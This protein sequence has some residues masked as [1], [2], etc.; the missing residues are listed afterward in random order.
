MASLVE[1]ISVLAAEASP[2]IDLDF[3]NIGGR[4]QAF[5]GETT[6][7]IFPILL[8][9]AIAA[10]LIAFLV[11]YFEFATS[12]NP[13]S[14]LRKALRGILVLIGLFVVF[15]SMHEITQ[16]AGASI[17]VM[18][19]QGETGDESEQANGAIALYN[20]AMDYFFILL[21]G[22]LFV[23][24]ACSLIVLLWGLGQ[25]VLW[26]PGDPERRNATKMIGRAAIGVLGVIVPLGMQFPQYTS[27]SLA[28]G[29][30]L[31]LISKGGVI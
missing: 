29:V 10:A 28:H 3:D 4:I 6:D 20:N 11:G 14:G 12:L 22:G 18:G 9:L 23:I 19:A 25:I 17:S 13:H 21:L 5:V 24:A 7:L 26:Q 2:S 15:G 31:L 27:F 8:L 1:L 16:L 30:I